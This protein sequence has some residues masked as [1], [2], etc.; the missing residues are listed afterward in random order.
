MLKL[1]E[2]AHEIYI[3]HALALILKT[4]NWM[5]FIVFLYSNTLLAICRKTQEISTSKCH[6]LYQSITFC[7]KKQNQIEHFDISK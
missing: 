1:K 5:S 4:E 7:V 6:I 3:L 2:K